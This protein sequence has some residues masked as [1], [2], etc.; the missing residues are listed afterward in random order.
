MG[1][2]IRMERK[3]EPIVSISVFRKAGN[4]MLLISLP[5]IIDVPN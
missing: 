3:I 1:T 2:D 5:E 4:T